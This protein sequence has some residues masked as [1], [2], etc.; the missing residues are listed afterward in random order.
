MAILDHLSEFTFSRH[1]HQITGNYRNKQYKN[2][3]CF[4]FRIIS[5]K[6]QGCFRHIF[7]LV[8]LIVKQWPENLDKSY[9]RNEVFRHLY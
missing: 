1:V 9:V 5:T 3:F 4:N 8:F 7:W 6:D 2:N